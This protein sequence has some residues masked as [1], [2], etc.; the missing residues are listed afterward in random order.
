[1]ANETSL[2][3]CP[4]ATVRKVALMKIEETRAHVKKRVTEIAQ[5]QVDYMTEYSE[6]RSKSIFRFLR[7]EI[8]QIPT[9][10]EY[11]DLFYRLYGEKTVNSVNCVDYEDAFYELYTL[12]GREFSRLKFFSNLPEYLND[13]EVYLS[14]SDAMLLSYNRLSKKQQ[15]L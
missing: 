12:Q 2:I 1:M 10:D 11:V 7:K 8:G 4:A 13:I 5:Q 3:K 6:K 15:V 9:V 14:V